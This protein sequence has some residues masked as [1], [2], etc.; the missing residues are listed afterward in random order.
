MAHAVAEPLDP[1][2]DHPRVEHDV[3][4][5]DRRQRRAARTSGR[6]PRDDHRRPVGDRGLRAVSG[7]VDPGRRIDGRS[8]RPQARVPLRRRCFSRVASVLCGV[9]TSPG[10]LIVG[11]ALQGIGAAFLVPGSLAIISATFDERERGRAIG[12][13]S[14]FSAITTAIGPVSGGWLVEHVSWRAVFFLNVPARCHRARAVA[15]IHEREPRS[16]PNDPDRLDRRGARRPRPGRHRLRTARMAAARRHPSTRAGRARDRSLLARAAVRRGASCA[17]PDV[18]ARALP[19]A[20]VYARQCPDA[21]AVCR[22]ERR[23]C[24]SCR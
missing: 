13:W 3:Y 17:E 9:A 14:G 4:R 20:N 16:V 1:G 10:T 11:R 12:T 5:R 18:A 7:R 15:P 6:P 8:V 22:A 2:R 23:A 21:A 19:L 24:S